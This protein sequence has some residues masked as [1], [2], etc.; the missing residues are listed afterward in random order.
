MSST[1][2]VSSSGAGHRFAPRAEHREIVFL[3]GSGLSARTGLGTFR[4]PAGLWALDPQIEA[5]MH[6]DRL[7]D[8]LPDLW[9]VW[10]SMARIATAHGPTPG[11]RAIA[12]MGAPVI[13]QNIDGL[14]QAAGSEIVA[15]LHGSALHAICLD[16]GCRWREP[17]TPGEGSAAEDHGVAAGCPRCGAPTRPDVVLFDEQLPADAFELAMR[18]AQRA[19]LLVA[20]GTSGVVFP[21]AQLAPLAKESGAETVLID[22]DPP[23]SPQL[24]AAFDHVIAEDAHE[25]L[26]AWE[27]AAHG[28]GTSSFLEPF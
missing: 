23:Q 2:A 20:V 10:G 14:H 17:L 18:L 4:G 15:E 13:T 16:P 21:A 28:V 25:V 1:G 6:A 19:D 22:I 12:R 8:S 7:P 26:P 11:H 27:R 5:A 24:R 3:T 9:R